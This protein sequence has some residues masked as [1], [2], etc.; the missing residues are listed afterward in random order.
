M[1]THFGDVCSA[2]SRF[3][4]R[5]RFDPRP[6]INLALMHCLL[7]TRRTGASSLTFLEGRIQRNRSEEKTERAE[8]KHAH[9]KVKYSLEIICVSLHESFIKSTSMKEI[10]SVH[11]NLLYVNYS[12]F[13]KSWKNMEIHEVRLPEIGRKIERV[14]LDFISFSNITRKLRIMHSWNTKCRWFSGQ[15][16]WFLFLWMRSW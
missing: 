7:V 5:E 10:L 16:L 12:L 4:S 9:K 2:H 11:D 1:E 13:V 8:D 15:E 3:I 6:A 14:P